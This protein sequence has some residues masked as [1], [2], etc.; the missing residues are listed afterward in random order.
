[1][2]DASAALL[3]ASCSD[4][5]YR[6]NYAEYRVAAA[7]G[8]AVAAG[9]A[10]AADA[11]FDVGAADAAFDV[12]AADIV[13]TKHHQLTALSALDPITFFVDYLVP[14]KPVL[15]ET[16]ATAD[17][18]AHGAWVLPDG[19]VNRS[20]LLCQYGKE[21]VVPLTHCVPPTASQLNLPDEAPL[22]AY[23]QYLHQRRRRDEAEQGEAECAPHN[24]WQGLGDD[25]AHVIPGQKESKDEPPLL[26]HFK[27][28]VY[29]KDWHAALVDEAAGRESSTAVPT[30]FKPTGD[31]L[32]EFCPSLFL[33]L[34]F[35]SVLAY[36][37]PH[38]DCAWTVQCC[39]PSFPALARTRTHAHCS[40]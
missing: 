38:S 9:T 34:L 30:P 24:L 5:T 20:G 22:E 19:S 29:L 39:S 1:M 27:H 14:N 8:V 25:T 16:F 2:S 32:N 36:Y 13:G 11:A 10:G 26:Q 31:W 6:R 40:C 4:S 3:A 17:W 15:L 7:S 21:E 37:C 33:P 12:G 35:G 23:M 28:A 18:P